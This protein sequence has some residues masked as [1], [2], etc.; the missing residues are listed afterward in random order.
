MPTRDR[1]GSRRPGR[2]EVHRR[3]ASTGRKRRAIVYS[4]SRAFGSQATSGA[5]T[6][7]A[8][9]LPEPPSAGMARAHRKR[10]APVTS[11]GIKAEVSA[12][13]TNRSR[14]AAQT[15]AAPSSAVGPTSVDPEK[16]SGCR[17]GSRT[18]PWSSSPPEVPVDRA[19]AQLTTTTVVAPAAASP[20]SRQSRSSPPG[21]RAAATT[22]A[23]KE[24]VV[25]ITRASESPSASA[26]AAMASAR[27]PLRLPNSR[28]GA[29]G[30]MRRRGRRPGPAGGDRQC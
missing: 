19:I 5:T 23:S 1:P 4:G 8:P 17:R 12:G 15:A 27:S 11:H 16:T 29:R 24:N 9:R 13:R 18:M 7:S 25:T 21:E 28:R 2:P 3:T 20:T 30:T 6:S 26:S 22:T 10:P 14:V